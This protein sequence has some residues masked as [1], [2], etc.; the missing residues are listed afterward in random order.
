MNGTTARELALTL[1]VT[2]LL[3]ASPRDLDAKGRTAGADD[4]PSEFAYTRTPKYRRFMALLRAAGRGDVRQ[5]Q[6]LI[7]RGVDV[8]GRDV[9]DDVAPT[10]RPLAEAS[11]KG[12]LAVV[13]VLLAAGARVD[14]CCC[15]CVTALHYAIRERHAEVVV[16]LLEAGASP[17]RTYDARLS[18]LELA[19]QTGDARIVGLI[20]AAVAKGPKPAPPRSAQPQR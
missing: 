16:R 3:L 15:S 20:E 5:V 6:A 1:A 19:R 14:S 4:V 18:P 12:H 2:S 11:E 13:N 7:R 17:I 10:N 8:N 9:G